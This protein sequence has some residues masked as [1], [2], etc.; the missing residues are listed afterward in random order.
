MVYYL[1]RSCTLRRI[2]NCSRS[3]S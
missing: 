3:F 1:F 2:E